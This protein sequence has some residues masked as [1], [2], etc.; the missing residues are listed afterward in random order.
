MDS[1]DEIVVAWGAV[2]PDLD[3]SPMRCSAG[4]AR[5]SEL[6]GEQREYA[7]AARGLGT[8]E[9]DVL[10]ALRRSAG[11]A[12]LTPGQLLEATHV[13]S[14]TMSN[15]LERLARRGLVTRRP[16]LKMGANSWSA[17]HRSASGVSTVR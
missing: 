9:F 13:T 3:V 12:E 5:L 4:C 10:A 8:Q 14:S 17:G 1:V 2:Q 7:F 11:S 16:D 15:R 6:L